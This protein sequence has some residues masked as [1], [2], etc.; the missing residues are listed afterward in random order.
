M[1]Q[2]PLAVT[3]RWSMFALLFGIRRSC[4]SLSLSGKP[5]E[6]LTKSLF[7]SCA[8]VPGGCGVQPWGG[9]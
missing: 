3:A 9:T 6:A 1:T 5:V 4:N 2:T 7:S 8:A